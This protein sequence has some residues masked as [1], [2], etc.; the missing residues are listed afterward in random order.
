[1]KNIFV[2]FDLEEK[3]KLLLS[4][5][6]QLAE[7][8]GSKIWVVHIAAPNPDFVGFDIGPQYIRDTRADELRA[9]HRYLQEMAAGLEA[10]GIA[11]EALLIQGPT[12]EMILEEAQKLNADLIVAGLHDRGFL[13]KALFGDTVKQLLKKSK[14]PLLIVPVD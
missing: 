2:A 7:K 6:K 12:V 13:H 10:E 5:A 3:S 9:E 14:T 8:F 11:A 1:M 4:H